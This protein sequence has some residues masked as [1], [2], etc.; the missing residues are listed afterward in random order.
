MCYA[1]MVLALGPRR[2]AGR[3][4]E[5]GAAGAIVP[6]LPLEES[7][8]IGEALEAEGLAL[9]PLVAP[10]TRPIAAGASASRLAASSTSS[11]PWG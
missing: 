1:N 9:I 7:G 4:A 10:T 2:F 11:R 6:D 5:A 3:L 8:E